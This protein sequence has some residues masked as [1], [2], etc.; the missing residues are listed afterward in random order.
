[1]ENYNSKVLTPIW[2]G[3]DFPLKALVP[4][5][6]SNTH[7]LFQ[8]RSHALFLF[9]FGWDLYSL[10]DCITAKNIFCTELYPSCHYDIYFRIYGTK[11]SPIHDTSSNVI[12]YFSETRIHRLSVLLGEDGQNWL[13]AT[14]ILW[15][16]P[17]ICG[18]FSS[19][20]RVALKW[21]VLEG[22][23]VSRNHKILEFI[24]ITL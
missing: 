10:V 22:I 12:L 4:F 18:T 24:L 1:M 8:I 2:L 19:T 23:A 9:I 16:L 21:K 11:V 7:R 3:S 14:I 6:M 15:P 17:N 13:L 5:V 20:H